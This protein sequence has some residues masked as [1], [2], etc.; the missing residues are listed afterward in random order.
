MPRDHEVLAPLTAEAADPYPSL[1]PQTRAEVLNRLY[2]DM[3]ARDVLR[4][5]I[6]EAFPG[7]RIAL[8]SSFG[9][10]SAAL[11]ALVAD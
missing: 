8:V 2:A 7:G 6:R 10:E 5:A 4:E 1:A 3:D 11:L 9:A